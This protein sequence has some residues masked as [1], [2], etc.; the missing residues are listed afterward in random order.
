MSVAESLGEKMKSCVFPLTRMSRRFTCSQLEQRNKLKCALQHRRVVAFSSNR[1]QW[2]FNW[3]HPTWHLMTC[4]G[5][6]ITK[7]SFLIRFMFSYKTE[8]ICYS[9]KRFLRKHNIPGGG[10][11]DEAPLPGC[12]IT[13]MRQ[14]QVSQTT[15]EWVIKFTWPMHNLLQREAKT[16]WWI[17]AIDS[18]HESH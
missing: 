6:R 15:Q 9:L 11:S 12:P 3:S 2:P 7:H 16:A 13:L 4:R 10:W 18:L 14:P 8:T 17:S 5:L 1:P